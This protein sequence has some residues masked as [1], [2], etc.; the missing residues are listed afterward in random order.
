M[1]HDENTGLNPIAGEIRC[2]G[3]CNMWFFSS[4][5]LWTVLTDSFST[6]NLQAPGL[7]ASSRSSRTGRIYHAALRYCTKTVSCWFE[8]Q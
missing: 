5:R 8:V 3:E 1:S 6:V 2:V 7:D 4:M